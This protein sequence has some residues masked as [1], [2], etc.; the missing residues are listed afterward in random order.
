MHH[1]FAKYGQGE[2][3]VYLHANNC[4]AQNKNNASIQY[5]MWRV[6]T[7]RFFGLFK[8]SFQRS[9]V[10]TLSDIE[11]VMKHSTK[12]DQNLAQHIRSC[13]GVVT[14]YQWSKYMFK[15]FRSIPN[16]LLSHNFRVTVN[17]QVLCICVNFQT[18]MKCNSIFLRLVLMWRKCLFCQA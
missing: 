12:E 15:F 11:H 6:M 17:N 7:G 13:G 18:R 1:Y 3:A 8:M 4:T 9:S 5:L 16:I 10:S 2:K 14:F